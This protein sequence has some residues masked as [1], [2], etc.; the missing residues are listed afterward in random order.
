[1]FSCAC[2]GH[3]SMLCYGGQDAVERI[4]SAHKSNRNAEKGTR[5]LGQSDQGDRRFKETREMQI[6]KRL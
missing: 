2:T 3:H 4:A 1:M 5:A 6:N